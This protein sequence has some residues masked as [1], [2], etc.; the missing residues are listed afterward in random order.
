VVEK[1]RERFTVPV[2]HVVT[3]LAAEREEIRS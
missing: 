3:D 2:T 1:A